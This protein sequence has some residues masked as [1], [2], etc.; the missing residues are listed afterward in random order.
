MMT[1]NNTLRHDMLPSEAR[2][3]ID[4]QVKNFLASGGKIQQIPEGISNG[5]DLG[6]K[7]LSVQRS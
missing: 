4:G 7:A 3:I 1:N 5:E 6:R 2:K